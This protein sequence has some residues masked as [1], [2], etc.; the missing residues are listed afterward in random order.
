MRVKGK[1][2]VSMEALGIAPNYYINLS[3]ACHILICRKSFVY[4]KSGTSSTTSFT[5]TNEEQPVIY[6]SNYI[7]LL[8]IMIMRGVTLFSTSV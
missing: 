4:F 3:H 2:H 5:F 7:I 8:S 1:F 6:V